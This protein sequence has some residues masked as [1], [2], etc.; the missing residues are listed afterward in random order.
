M[1]KALRVGVAALCW[2]IAARGA[3]AHALARG[4]YSIRLS[5]NGLEAAWRGVPFL[6]GSR[7]HIA[8]PG[9]QGAFYTGGDLTRSPTATV[10]AGPDRLAVT[11]TAPE[12]GGAIA[13][14]F[15]LD[16][17]GLTVT[18]AL[19]I[20]EAIP[21]SP[22]EYCSGILPA[23]RVA[24][25]RYR[26]R[27]LLGEGDWDPL[28]VEKPSETGPGTHLIQGGLTGLEV[29]APGMRV[30]AEVLEGPPLQFFDMRSRDYPE[31]QRHYWLLQS[32][33]AAR[34]EVRFVVRYRVS[35]ESVSAPAS[36][37]GPVITEGDAMVPLRTIAVAP[38]A[39]PVEKAAARE[40]LGYLQRMGSADIA[41]VDQADGTLPARGTIFVGQHPAAGALLD[42]ASLQGQGPDGFVLCSRGGNVLAAGK[43]HR[44]TVY[45]VYRLLERMGCRFYARELEVV[46][47]SP[48]PLGAPFEVRDSAAFEWRAMLGTIAPMK[49]SLSPGEWEASVAGTEV[50]K[51][52]AFPKGG[53]WHHTMGFL[54]PAEPLAMEH[55]EYLALIRGERRVTEPAVQQYCLSNPGL[56]AAM[57]D[58]VLEWIA[59]DPDK[60]YYP[61][62]YGD[63]VS[64]CE[65]DRCKALYAEKG[66]I[67]DAVIWFDNQIARE[68]AA[69]YPGKF[70]T[71]LAYHSTRTPPRQV[72]P[73]PN[74]LIV[75]CA[76][77]ECQARPWSHPVN[78]RRRVSQDLEGWVALHP[79]GPKG[80]LTF[81]YPT[82]YNYAGFTYPALYAFVENVRYY[83]RLGLRGVYICGLGSWKH[84]E[85]AYSY[86]IPRIL[87]N[88]QQDLGA[89]LDEFCAA[90]YGPAAGPMR[91]YIEFLHR[92]AMES[93][94]EGVMDC[95]AGPGQAFFRELYTPDFVARAY[96]LF[97]AAEAAAADPVVRRRIAKEKWGFLFT[98]LY[99][100]GARSGE[101][102]PAATPQGIE[103]RLPG[104]DEYRRLAELLEAHRQFQRPWVINPRAWHHYSLSALVGFEPDREPWWE[105]PRLRELMA[106]PEAAFRAS[107]EAER[108][109]L[110]GLVTL[111]N[112]D[113]QAIVV[114]AL[115]GRLWRLY[116]KGLRADLLRRSPLP[117]AGLPDGLPEATYVSL[118]G[119][120][121]Y[122]AGAFGSPGWGRPYEAVPA[123]DGRSVTLTAS[124]PNGLRL[125]R[126]IALAPDRP[127]VTVDSHLE[128]AG[129]ETVKGALLR[130]HPEFLPQAEGETPEL[131]I[132]TGDGGWRAVP[133]PA[134]E[135]VLAGADRPA[136]AWAFRFPQA[137]LRLENVFEPG[138]VETCMA[139]NGNRFF[140]LELF[141]PARDLA[142]GESLRLR[143]R[144][145]LTREP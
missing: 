143:H 14:E 70:V 61:V 29:A 33:T 47:A 123:P 69:R 85:H 83:Q 124:F 142:P 26:P 55:P 56:L 34:G 18:T 54:L 78:V 139:Y 117:A 94:C 48:A 119:Y 101:I 114:P 136:G 71:I 6:C 46:P 20:A 3:D 89:L 129:A 96:G 9:W 52:M 23:D 80:I 73:E 38:G 36:G 109:R 134:G 60:D 122:T 92:R 19:R 111:E 110:R 91:E 16:D 27:L 76:I 112:G 106:D 75:F 58:K 126:V 1:H 137:K 67:T 84:L 43:N 15:R 24:G 104:L 95:H 135:T 49:C 45:A 128:N 30:E 144:F 99:L 53:F 13:H 41:L 42:A 12:V 62:H 22:A 77:V 5:A 127:E 2:G 68:V 118:G 141:S 93:E 31:A 102:L 63:V 57:T 11:D 25:G 28:P 113:L 100:H 97:A 88:P 130:A 132:R 116:H 105:D 103:T 140:N 21:P 64:F 37:R 51:M 107:R 74:L 108:E 65:C 131:H 98:D 79:L 120:E 145:V 66:S 17:D 39:H 59:S 81:E 10:T 32:F 90:W 7:L 4:E 125:V 133:C 40:L 82:T 138:Q 35:A 87:W 72:R 8:R 50:P 115:G 86:V 121:E 44:G